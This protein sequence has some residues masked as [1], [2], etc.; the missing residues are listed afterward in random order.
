MPARRD[1]CGRNL[2][3]G[4]FPKWAWLSSLAAASLS[5][6]APV[7][8]QDS[9]VRI[10]MQGELSFGTFMVFGNGSRRVSS[11]G[12][13]SDNAIVPLE[14]NT[15][16]PARVTIE[17]DRGNNSRDPLDVLI[18]AVISTPGRQRFGGVEA[19]V[20]RLFTDVP[21]HRRVSSGEVMRIR[22]TNCRARLCS[23][24][25]NV[26]GRLR[27]NRLYGGAKIDIPL[28]VDARVVSVD[29]Q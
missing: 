29:R 19:R 16:Q 8:A 9:G 13:V 1:L 27:I 22:L 10:R 6:G 12:I 25:F 26:G 17:Y 23:R 24:S 20:A 14:G 4:L 3:F 15:P 11:S 18:E 21:G 7:F 5:L 28:A 2:N